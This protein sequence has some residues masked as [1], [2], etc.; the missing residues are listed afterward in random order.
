MRQQEPAAHRKGDPMIYAGVDI[1]KM[2]HVIGAVDEAG[3]E[4]ARPMA[5]KN[6]E[7]GFERCIAWLESVAESEDDVFV[8]M[9]ATV[10]FATL[11]F[12]FS[13]HIFFGFH[14]FRQ[15]R[16]SDFPS[17]RTYPS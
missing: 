5:F 10:C 9:E 11:F 15:R 1:A 16:A 7:A 2:D 13:Q 14:V 12:R 4:V 8:G 3:A 17:L 6:T